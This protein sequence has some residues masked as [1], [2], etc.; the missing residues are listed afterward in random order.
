M[1]N[2]ID[3]IEVMESCGEFYE[4]TEVTDGYS[5]I[6][7]SL[8]LNFEDPD[9][10]INEHQQIIKI[11]EAI[12]NWLD[13]NVEADW[14]LDLNL[15]VVEFPSSEDSWRFLEWLEEYEARDEILCDQE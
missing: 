15:M 10:K 4:V 14:Y 5:T 7:V 11:D 9:P 8:L 13:N 12:I 6:D 1:I 3:A 2:Y